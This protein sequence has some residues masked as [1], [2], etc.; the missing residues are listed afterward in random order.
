VGGGVLA[1]LPILFLGL[2]FDI[3]PMFIVGAGLVAAAFPLSITFT[4]DSQIGRVLFG[5]VGFATLTLTLLLFLD[6]FVSVLPEKAFSGLFV[7]SLVAC[8]LSTL[9]ALIPGPAES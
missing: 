3:E 9:A 7:L 4:N 8:G 2:G 6:S 5:F 1:G